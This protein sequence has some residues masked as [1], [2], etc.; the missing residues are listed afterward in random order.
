MYLHAHA[1]TH[2]CTLGVARAVQ[3]GGTLQKANKQTLFSLQRLDLTTPTTRTARENNGHSND[4]RDVD[5]GVIKETE[6]IR[7]REIYVRSHTRNL[8]PGFPQPRDHHHEEDEEAEPLPVYASSQDLQR[9]LV[10]SSC[11]RS[12]S[13]R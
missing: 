1:C 7:P 11:Q 13:S 4:Q 8:S 3:G 9:V 6:C 5:S 2:A 12:S 10:P